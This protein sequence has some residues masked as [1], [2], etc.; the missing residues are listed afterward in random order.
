MSTK[1]NSVT[2]WNRAAI[3]VWSLAGLTVG[4]FIW[5]MI[6]P[7]FWWGK[8]VGFLLIL[9]ALVVAGLALN[10]VVYLFT[11]IGVDYQR[12]LF[13]TS[14]TLSVILGWYVGPRVIWI[15]FGAIALST[16]LSLAILLRRPPT[17]TFSRW[18]LGFWGLGLLVVGLFF[19]TRLRP[20]IDT[21]LT[22]YK[23]KGTPPHELTN[24]AEPGSFAVKRVS[25]GPAQDRHR[26]RYQQKVA[27]RASSV[28]ATSL[29]PG[30][31]GLSGWLRSSYW[32]FGPQNIP[33][34]AT[35]WVPDA[36]GP[37]PVVLIIHGDHVMEEYNSELG[38]AYLGQLLASRGALVIAVDLNFMN[39]SLADLP[40]LFFRNKLG[41][42]AHHDARAWLALQ[43]LESLRQWQNDPAHP[44]H[45]RIDLSRIVIIGHSV[46]S[47]AASIA[48]FFN[49]LSRHPDHSDIIFPDRFGIRGIVSLAG[50]E[51][52]YQPR[53]A[54]IW[55]DN[56]HYLALHGSRDAQV[57]SF[58]AL[59]Q[60]ARTRWTN[61]SHYFKAALLIQGLHHNSF[62][63]EWGPIDVPDF[64]GWVID[65]TGNI[66]PLPGRQ[67]ISV[68][69]SAF[70]EYVL[71]DQKEYT[72][73]LMDPRRA[74]PWIPPTYIEAKAHESHDRVLSNFE[75][76]AD[77]STTTWPEGKISGC[78]LLMWRERRIQTK[79][80]I[81]EDHAVEIKWLSTQETSP[82][83][84]LQFESPLT[85]TPTSSTST[86]G[87]Y[88]VMSAAL[89]QRQPVDFSISIVDSYKQSATIALST[90]QLLYPTLT[91]QTRQPGLEHRPLHELTF[92]RF[93]L[94]KLAFTNV[95]PELRFEQLEAIELKFDRTPH[96]HLWIESIGLGR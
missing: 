73:V 81:L 20:P 56:T 68:F 89:G 8:L 40:G 39:T 51:G 85:Q 75:E 33:L 62:N 21:Y 54:P 22:N 79:N 93:H 35:A 65:S 66:P 88:L 6:V 86:S 47:E 49:T 10:T 29:M 24:P 58:G 59:A 46:G 52:E 91:T 7:H 71:H 23:L 84:R 43:H 80:R 16:C 12:A 37:R 18:N 14:P 45:K 87:I 28:D 94:P 69:V 53:N 83:W 60:Y 48:A 95:N 92:R 11:T 70:I 25:Y 41:L 34:Q 15:Y 36:P 77:L 63:S 82:F 17:N 4:W 57:Y 13:I 9:A 26:T 90:D 74:A 27:F 2:I 31:T 19:M 76:D 30:W 78:G 96:G 64:W 32:G 55:L 42:H 72:S 61:Q 38:Y 5:V 50:G 1:D 67:I 3:G 44:W